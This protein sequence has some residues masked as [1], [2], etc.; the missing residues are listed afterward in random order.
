[1]PRNGTSGRATAKMSWDS[2][3]NLRLRPHAP[4]KGRGRLQRAVRRAFLV[5][6][7]VSTATVFDWCY[8]RRPKMRRSQLNRRRVHELLR[9]IAD[10]IGRADT[11]GRPRI[12]RLK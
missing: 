4:A 11:V 6:D 3:P 9:E 2:F 8:A 12:W 10:P 7:Q 5:A 1:M